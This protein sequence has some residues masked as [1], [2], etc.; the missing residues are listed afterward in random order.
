MMDQVANL[1]TSRG[2]LKVRPLDIFC[3]W[4]DAF[5]STKHL[6]RSLQAK[7]IELESSE[8]FRSNYQSTG[9]MG[10]RRTC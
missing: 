6:P 2:Q 1:W 8:G 10:D 5:G 3:F 9:N 4:F 7:K